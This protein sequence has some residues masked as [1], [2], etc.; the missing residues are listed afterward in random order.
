MRRIPA[1]RDFIDAH[2][3]RLQENAYVEIFA[4]DGCGAESAWRRKSWY[5]DRAE[6][7]KRRK[8]RDNPDVW[9]QWV[10]SWPKTKRLTYTGAAAIRASPRALRDFRMNQ[11]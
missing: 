4:S 2:G 10:S 7:R 1:Y 5:R 9:S 6:A 11:V 3:G 8:S